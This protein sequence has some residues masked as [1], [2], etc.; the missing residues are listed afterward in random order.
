MAALR[1]GGLPAIKL[2]LLAWFEACREEPRLIWH[3]T[4]VRVGVYLIAGLLLIKVVGLVFSL[5]APGGP[6]PVPFS[7]TADFH[8]VCMNEQCGHHFV[9]NRKFGFDDF[10]V[11][12]PKCG[13]NTGMHARRCV[14]DTCKGRW[15]APVSRVGGL[16]CPHCDSRLGAGS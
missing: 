5:A 15:V 7:R 9:I 12:C 2:R 14:S 3:T 8:V 4:A 10:P 11:A 13:K 16:Y 1:Q 6:E